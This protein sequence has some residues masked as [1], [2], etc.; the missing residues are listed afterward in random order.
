M[1]TTFKML[2]FLCVLFFQVNI[3]AQEM[4][5][6]V[7]VQTK[8]FFKIISLE[9]NLFE[10]PNEEIVLGIVYQGNFRLSE[11]T[12]EEFLKFVK[13]E[14]MYSLNNKRIRYV[15]I[16]LDKEDLEI[17]IKKHQLDVL[18]IAPLRAYDI[19]DIQKK[20]EELQVFTLASIVE[21]VNSGLAV[22]LDIVADKPQIVIN[23]KNTKA[24]GADFSSRLLKIARTIE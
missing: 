7:E 11:I 16:N 18:Y 19:H 4:L 1:K 15:T 17:S 21:Y 22:G 24:Q 12:R 23:L 2:P 9:R 8:L 6:P 5:V 13:N 10:K 14:D 3:A 20:S